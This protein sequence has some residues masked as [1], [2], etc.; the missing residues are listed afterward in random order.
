M[1]VKES[2]DRLVSFGIVK[3]EPIDGETRS[4]KDRLI[5]SV[6][7]LVYVVVDRKIYYFNDAIKEWTPNQGSTYFDLARLLNLPAGK[8]TIFEVVSKAPVYVD[9]KS[10]VKAEHALT[11]PPSDKILPYTVFEAFSDLFM[12]HYG[13]AY[14]T[15]CKERDLRHCKILLDLI[16]SNG[17]YPDSIYKGFLQWVFSVKGKEPR[18]GVLNCGILPYLWRDYEI[19]EANRWLQAMGS[20]VS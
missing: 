1:D 17:K 16:R 18:Y 20:Y 14:D 12:Q 13:R 4:Q 5:G 7:P 6:Y 8:T 10:L 11:K 2:L 19:H 15:K 3:V 9:I